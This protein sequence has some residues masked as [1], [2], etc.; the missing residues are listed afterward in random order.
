VAS[1]EPQLISTQPTHKDVACWGILGAKEST[2]KCFRRELGRL[3]LFGRRLCRGCFLN[4][5]HKEEACDF[6]VGVS[7]YSHH[8]LSMW[9]SKAH[10]T[11]ANPNIRPNQTSSRAFLSRFPS[12]CVILSFAI[13]KNS[14][15]PMQ[16]F[17]AS[18]IRRN[19]EIGT[20]IVSR[21]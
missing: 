15:D 5:Q 8:G 2:A 3:R 6:H 17:F 11:N 20:L 1:I 21:S 19:S 16:S 18:S 12:V 4:W 10:S 13:S 9:H 14:I 7:L